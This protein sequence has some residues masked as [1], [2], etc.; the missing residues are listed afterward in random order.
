MQWHEALFLAVLVAAIIRL[1]IGPRYHWLTFPRIAVPGL[2]LAS[3]ALQDLRWQ[4]FPAALALGLIMLGALKRNASGT[5]LRLLAAV[6]LVMLAACSVVL[7]LF[8]PLPDLPEPA[9]PFGVGTFDL[10][11]TDSSRPERYS[12]ER[13]RELYLEV[14]YPAGKE[15]L[16]DYPVRTLFHD[17]YRGEFNRTSL[18][19]G[20]LKQVE[21]HSH[22][23]APAA[24]AGDRGFPVVLFNHALDFGFTSQNLLLMEHLASNGYVVVSIAHP[25]QT[26]KVNLE[27]AGTVFRAGGLPGD[28]APPRPELP[29]GIVSTVLEATGDIRQVSRLKSELLPGA[30]EFLSLE[31]ARKPEFISRLLGSPA[32]EPFSKHLTAELI[33]DFYY[34]DYV[35]EN[36]LVGYW[37]E[38]NQFVAGALTD[39]QAPIAGFP[40]ILDPG[41][42]GA[43]GMSYGGAAAG[44]FCKVDS[45][46][47]AGINLDGTQFGRHWDRRVQVPFLML[48]NDEHQGGN[49]YA[50]LPPEADFLDLRVKG[51]TH[52]DFT[53]FAW[54][55]P[56]LKFAGFSG[57]IEGMRMAMVINSVQLDFLDRYLKGMPVDDPAAGRYPELVERSPP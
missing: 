57:D 50:Y 48:Y 7:T 44:E 38:D 2:V 24:Q 56:I 4:M 47:K 25:Y 53:D 30:E 26:A 22:V 37:V 21:T 45:R 19:F 46:C 15:S 41:R 23:N 10:S 5:G 49:D 1:V 16:R 28:I 20:Y 29:K 31:E 54:L 36:S 34:H 55:W 17:L 43:I 8:M 6:P 12:P 33:E 42:L 39:L 9:G 13:N 51:S 18:I 52:M 32:L 14:W 35:V 11:I 3:M 27:G 40:E